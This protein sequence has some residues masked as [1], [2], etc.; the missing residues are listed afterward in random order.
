M[1]LLCEAETRIEIAPEA[2]ARCRDAR[3]VVIDHL[4]GGRPLYG[5]NLGVGAMKSFRFEGD[6]FVSL[7]ETLVL[8]HTVG[9]GDALPPGVVRLALALRLNTLLVGRSGCSQEF[10]QAVA[11]LLAAGITP[12]VEGYG[13]VGC[14]DILANGQIGAAL[15]GHGDG[16]C[17]G[18]VAPMAELLAEHKLEPH[19]MRA[20]DAISAISSNVVSLAGAVFAVR[21]AVR[22]IDLMLTASVTAAAALAGAPDPWRAA[23]LHGR[24]STAAIGQWL[25]ETHREA[26]WPREDTVHDSLG[27]R[28]LADIY[29]PIYDALAALIDEIE[30]LTDFV[31]ENPIVTDGTI[32]ASGGSHLLSLGLKLDGARLALTHAARNGYNH[33]AQLIAGRSGGLPVNLAAPGSVMTGF[34]P[35]LKV[36]GALVTEAFSNAAPVSSLPLVMASGL[37]DEAL[38]LTLAIDKLDRQSA[39]VETLAAVVAVMASQA[40]E[41]SGLSRA[42]PLAA[43]FDTVRGVVPF[44]DRDRPMAGAIDRVRAAL[45]TAHPQIVAAGRFDLLPLRNLFDLPASGGGESPQN[46][47]VPLE[48]V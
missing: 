11:D 14:A 26:S 46:G 18:R 23:A 24:G 35:M 5:V 43:L 17:K 33:C 27:I 2:L 36:A 13:S 10:I 41:I 39:L 42:G 19:L 32:L 45:A 9:I 21:A 30:A 1:L 37:E 47:A 20:K 40:L 25:I 34:G 3:S 8:A 22:S 4:N 28:F 29:G 44:A 31:D 15:A 38:H 48:T 6:A 12:V 16:V 7:N